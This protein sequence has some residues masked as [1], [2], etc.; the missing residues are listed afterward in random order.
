M[1]PTQERIE[2]LK[3]MNLLLTWSEDER[4]TMA[5]LA[6]GVP[7]EADD[8]DLKSIAEDDDLYFDICRCFCSLTGAYGH[9]IFG[10]PSQV[11]ISKK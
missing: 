10:T 6:G 8:D 7:D 5:W 9:C 4:V 2:K 1:S 11:E 3:A